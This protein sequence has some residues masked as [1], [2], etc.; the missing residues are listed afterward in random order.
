MPPRKASSSKY[1]TQY[2]REFRR[3]LHS[4]GDGDLFNEIELMRY[5]N[6][7]V[8]KQMN[9]E[10]K[11]LSY[12]DRL[13]TLNAMTNS[14][15]KIAQLT[16]MQYKIFEPLCEMQ[17]KYRNEMEHTYSRISEIAEMLMGEEKVG[18]IEMD[19][20]GRVLRHESGEK[21]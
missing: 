13:A 1:E 20:L 19:A 21:E 7:V 2:N 9:V 3:I 12:H 11:K 18:E 6:L 16:Y 15:G 14:V 10:D 8:L 4:H 17:A 5:M